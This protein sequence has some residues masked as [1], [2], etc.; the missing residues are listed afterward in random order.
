MKSID[1]Y[2]DKFYFLLE[3]QIGDVKTLITENIDV[4]GRKTIINSDG[5]VTINNY[6]E[7]PQRIRMS[8]KLGNIN[9]VKIEPAGNGYNI[10]G[11]SG[12]TEFIERSKIK[13]I[14]SFVDKGTPS[15]IDSGSMIKPNVELKKA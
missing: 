11:K 14:I 12:R 3:T 4:E 9:V 7:I 15:V 10:T 6:K 1:E 5:T 13:Q 2:K 8:T